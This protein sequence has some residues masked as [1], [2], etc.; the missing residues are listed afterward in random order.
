MT[1]L[2]KH[3]PWTPDLMTSCPPGLRASP[4]G[5]E[6]LFLTSVL[7]SF[8]Q[9]WGTAVCRPLACREPKKCLEERAWLDTMGCHT[10]SHNTRIAGQDGAGCGKRGSGEPQAPRTSLTPVNVARTEVRAL[11]TWATSN[12]S[13]TLG[14]FESARV[15]SNN[16][17]RIK[18]A[19]SGKILSHTVLWGNKAFLWDIIL[20]CK[21]LQMWYQIFYRKDYRLFY[22]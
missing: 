14:M 5:R 22:Q 7:R 8:L 9:W 1:S 13:K 19:Y 16:S 10:P 12:G 15:L 11:G 6:S 18:N 4:R 21:S 20:G 2:L 17:K 3:A